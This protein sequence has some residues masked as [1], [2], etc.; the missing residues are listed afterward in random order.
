[1]S[2]GDVIAEGKTKMIIEDAD[3]EVLIL[4]KDDI[5]AGDGAKRDVLEDKAAC[6]T[7]TTCNVFEL[8]EGKRVKTHFVGRVDDV[9]FRARNVD[10]IPLELVARR[11]A[12]GSYLKRN[13]DVA[14]GT[15]FDDVVFEL[16]EKDDDNHDPKLEFDFEAGVLRRYVAHKP[17]D[18]AF[19]S[20]E[21]LATSRYSDLNREILTGL[22]GLTRIVFGIL[23]TA[24]SEHGGVLF[25]FKIEC[26]FDRETGELLV[27]DVIDSDSWRLRFGGVA[28]DKQAYRDDT[29][30]LPAIR[31]DYLQVAALTDLFV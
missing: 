6:S 16:F 14:D 29:K 28:M 11:I 4:S 9:T 17:R 24:W 20:E 13:P 1:M 3:G 27:A 8:L 22:D 26:G 5:T 21:P 19:M 7:R 18:E 25:D 2:L 31:K 30:S 10:M 12:T 23:E 15:V